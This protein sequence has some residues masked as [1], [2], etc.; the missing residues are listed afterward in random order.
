[1]QALLLKAAASQPYEEELRFVLSFYGSD[2]DSLLL[3]TH[4]EIFSQNFQ[5][6]REVVFSDILSFFRG[7]TPSQ[8]DLMSQVSKLVRLLLVMPATNAE[9]ERSFSAVQRIKTYLCSTMS[10]QRLNHLMLLHVHKSHTD[11]LDLIDVTNNSI[12]GGDHR[13][14]FFGSEFKQFD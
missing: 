1:V 6:V 3:S 10:Q 13:K 4:L 14:H 12:D 9:S 2:F 5:P 7:C 8:V 11:D